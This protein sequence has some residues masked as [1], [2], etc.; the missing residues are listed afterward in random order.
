MGGLFY[1]DEPG[2]LGAFVFFTVVLGGLGGIATGRAFANSWKPLLTLP[3][4][5]LAL[6]AAVRFLSYALASE[7]LLSLQYYIVSLLF[8]AFGAAYGFR[9]KRTEQMCRQYPWLFGKA[10]PVSW[11]HRG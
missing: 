3:F 8:V 11:S 7:D 6:A 1:P 4:A 5:L 9:A 2:A 10:G